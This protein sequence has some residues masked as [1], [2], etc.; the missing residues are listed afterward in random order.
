MAL[1]G[2]GTPASAIRIVDLQEPIR[3]EFRE[4]GTEASQVPIVRADISDAES[5][6][7]AFA[8]EWPEETADL[9]LT[10]FHTAAKMRWG[11]RS[12]LFW[13]RVAPVNID[14]TRNVIAASKVA[15]ASVLVMTSSASVEN[16]EVAW[17]PPP[18]KRYPR[19]FVQYLDGTGAG[20][21]VS[22]KPDWQYGILYART[23]GVAEKL[24]CEADGAETATG[25]LRTGVVR[26]GNPIYGHIRDPLV[27]QMLTLKWVPSFNAAWVQN[28]VHSANVA[29]AH[30]QL[31]AAL[32]G[33]HAG[34]VAGRPH[35]VTDDGPPIVTRDFY[36]LLS[37][38]SRSGFQATLPPPLLF[39]SM[40]YVIEAW[41]LLAVRFSFVRR[42]IGEPGPP[43]DVLQPGTGA[44]GVNSIINDSASRKAPEQGGL[45]YT[46]ICDTM[47]GVSDVVAHWN[48]RLEREEAE[49]KGKGESKKDE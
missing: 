32:L 28:W 1:L 2:N 31:E 16:R 25:T 22:D 5:V 40:F 27:G 24:V 14:G 41:A 36:A 13:D 45:G 8:V 39:L 6:A 35:I 19:N 3:D 37:A 4:A 33:E 23:K 49:E 10:V 7:A 26:P 43:I 46:P 15:G 47:E 29:L 42:L 12:N 20:G 11:E 17:F 44:A 21:A 30:S 9:E 48:R 38:T 34:R 18:W